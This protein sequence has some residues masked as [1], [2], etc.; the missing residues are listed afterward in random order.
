MSINRLPFVCKVH[1]DQRKH[2]T[3][4]QTPHTRTIK[5]HIRN[6]FNSITVQ[7]TF[8]FQKKHSFNT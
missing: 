5:K 6:I 1:L 8:C 3:Y 7:R 4:K 2:T